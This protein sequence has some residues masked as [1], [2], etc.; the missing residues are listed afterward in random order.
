[1]SNKETVVLCLVMVGMCI[2]AGAVLRLVRADDSPI[3]SLVGFIG[4]VCVMGLMA[5]G[6]AFCHLALKD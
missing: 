4:A 3:F 2:G 1:M 6:Y 5:V